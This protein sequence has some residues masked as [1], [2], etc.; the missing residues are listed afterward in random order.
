MECFIIVTVLWIFSVCVHEFGHAWAAYCGGD[1]TV[2]EKGYLTLN[3]LN[4]T[5]PVYSIVL[6]ALFMI[7]G[8]IG[9]PG[10]AVYIE[11]HL[12]RSR[13]WDTWVSLAGP[14]MHLPIIFWITLVFRTGLV[15]LSPEHLSSISLA[16]LLE[17]Q[18]SALLLNLIP[19]PPLDG[20]QALAPW[21]R[22]DV[23]QDLDAFSGYG[24]WII[25]GLFQIIPPLN[26]LF[27]EVVTGITGMLG[28]PSYLA[29][30]GWTAFQ[31]WKHG[32]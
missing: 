4:Y 21:L 14:A 11:R 28:V 10:G 17:L 27:W 9:L 30:Y 25:F 5:H 29:A 3:P 32:F 24:M 22:P 18:I 2:R 16:L 23:R 13:G 7:M 31:F 12:L 20:Y 26:D 6:P 15:P 19:V 1:H 8:G